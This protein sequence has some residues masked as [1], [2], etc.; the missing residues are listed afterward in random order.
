MPF[1]SHHTRV[2]AVVTP[3]RGCDLDTGR[4]PIGQTASPLESGSMPLI[5]FIWWSLLCFQLSLW[6][7]LHLATSPGQGSL[8]VAP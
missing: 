3:H 6:K 4:S 2:P 7:V 8:E 1:L 5:L